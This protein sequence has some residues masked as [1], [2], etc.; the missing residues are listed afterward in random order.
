MARAYLRAARANRVC[1][2]DNSLKGLSLGS[3]Q[4][5]SPQFELSGFICALSTSGHCALR[6]PTVFLVRIETI[7]TKNTVPDKNNQ[8]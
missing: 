8:A 4:D 6:A 1:C 7:R 2:T 3:I 5:R